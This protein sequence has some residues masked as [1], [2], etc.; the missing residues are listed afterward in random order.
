MGFFNC[1]IRST[2]DPFYE[3]VAVLRHQIIEKALH[4]ETTPHTV[5]WDRLANQ[6]VS[7]IGV[8]GFN[9]LYKRC[10]FLTQPRFPWLS[11]CELSCAVEQRFNALKDALETQ[12]PAVALEAN[13]RLL[14]TFTDILAMLIGEELTSSILRTAWGDQTPEKDCNRFVENV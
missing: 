8:E 7:I 3:S 12:T 11:G 5:L 10:L 9:A 2:D 1:V 6:I 14:K 13:S 4:P